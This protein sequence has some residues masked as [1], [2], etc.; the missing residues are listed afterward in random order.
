M[1][2]RKIILKPVIISARIISTL[3]VRGVPSITADGGVDDLTRGTAY[4]KQKH[5]EYNTQ[6]YHQP[7][8]EYDANTWNL[9]GGLADLEVV[10]AIGLHLADGHGWPQWKTGSEFKAIRDKTAADR[11]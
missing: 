4:G 6:R 5:D 8:D 3:P 2:R 10:Y 1:L 7:S 11:K 9:D